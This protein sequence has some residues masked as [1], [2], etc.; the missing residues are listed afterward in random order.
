MTAELATMIPG[1]GGYVLWVQIA[2]GDFAAWM[3]VRRPRQLALRL[4]GGGRAQG[5]NG[6]LSA[7]FDLALYPTLF[8]AYLSDLWCVRARA[9][10]VC[11]CAE[12]DARCAGPR[13][14][15]AASTLRRSSSWAGASC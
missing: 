11:K 7:V 9:R 2:F 12:H 13:S 4:A 10:L 14:T 8:A 15:L 3:T 5:V 6:V 1:N